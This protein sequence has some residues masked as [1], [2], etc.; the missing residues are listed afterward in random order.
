MVQLHLESNQ[1]LQRWIEIRSNSSVCSDGSIQ[2][3]EQIRSNFCD[4]WK[5][6][7]V[8]LDSVCE[9]VYGWLSKTV[10]QSKFELAE[11][12]PLSVDWR[13]EHIQIG[14]HKGAEQILSGAVTS[15]AQLFDLICAFVDDAG[16]QIPPFE[17]TDLAPTARLRP[18][19]RI[20]AFDLT[21]QVRVVCVDVSS[22]PNGHAGHVG[23]D[24]KGD[25]IIVDEWFIVRDQH[26]LWKSYDLE[27][28]AALLDLIYQ[29][30]KSKPMMHSRLFSE[31]MNSMW[32]AITITPEML[33]RFAETGK[34]TIEKCGAGTRTSS[35]SRSGPEHSLSHLR[36]ATQALPFDPWDF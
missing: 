5:P 23:S 25:E 4:E 13:I 1:S 12:S 31:L 36:S 6:I 17:L 20:R 14:A 19:K 11:Y 7:S 33:I 18:L 15:R 10:D 22:A 9:F 30:G 2:N 21:G 29:R 3:T 32:G 28:V 27:T 35:R 16:I 34:F 26:V 24:V 8:S